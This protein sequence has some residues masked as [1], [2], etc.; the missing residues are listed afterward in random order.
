MVC[1]RVFGNEST[2]AF[3]GAQGNFELNVYK[4]VIASASLESICLLADAAQ[5]FRTYCIEGIA[6]NSGRIEEL[7]KRSLMLVTALAPKIGYDNAARIARAAHLKGTSLRE[8][9]L[10]SG[11]ISAAD[12]DALVRPETM[13]APGD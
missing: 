4:P 7:M 13:L 2:I 9:A 1:A 8:E 10:A 6:A 5:S 12:Y 11:L 3:A